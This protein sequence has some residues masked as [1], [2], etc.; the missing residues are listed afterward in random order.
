MYEEEIYS[1]CIQISLSAQLPETEIVDITKYVLGSGG[2]TIYT[3]SRT[4]VRSRA[5]IIIARLALRLS[6]ITVYSRL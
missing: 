3:E 2:V 6:L 1:K 4:H 5:I